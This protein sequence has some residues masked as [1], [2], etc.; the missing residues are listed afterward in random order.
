MT[1]GPG[2][3]RKTVCDVWEGVLPE[4]RGVE[5]KEHEHMGGEWVKRSKGAKGSE[6]WRPL[7]GLGDVRVDTSFEFAEDL[8]PNCCSR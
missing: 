8:F 1:D 6:I 3:V 4:R 5:V 7:A 2:P